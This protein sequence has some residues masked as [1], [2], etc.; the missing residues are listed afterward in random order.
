MGVKP[1]NGRV[2]VSVTIAIPVRSGASTST[3]LVRSSTTILK[4]SDSSFEP[5]DGSSVVLDGFVL[6]GH[7]P[8]CVLVKSLN[9]RMDCLLQIPLDRLLALGDSLIGVAL[10]VS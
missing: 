7:L 4:G 2:S 5:V 10:P 9:Q 3:S 8:L 1:G 6:L